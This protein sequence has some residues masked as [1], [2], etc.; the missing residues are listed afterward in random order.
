MFG[1]DLVLNLCINQ[2]NVGNFKH[3]ILYTLRVFGCGKSFYIK[4]LQEKFKPYLVIVPRTD[5]YKL[6]KIY[7]SIN[8]SD[9]QLKVLNMDNT[10]WITNNEVYNLYAV[11]E[12]DTT[13]GSNTPIISDTIDSSSTINGHNTPTRSDNTG[14]SSTSNGSDNIGW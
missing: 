5:C 6:S 10:V 11:N 4:D 8:F 13:G 3:L 7:G 9:I 2:R 12:L 14:N 1:F